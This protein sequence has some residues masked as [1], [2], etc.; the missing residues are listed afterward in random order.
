MVAC[1][2]RK[3]GAHELSRT[4]RPKIGMAVHSKKVVNFHVEPLAA[5]GAGHRET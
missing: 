5:L 1:G 4:I 3:Q 2:T